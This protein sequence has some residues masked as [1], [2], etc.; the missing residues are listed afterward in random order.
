MSASVIERRAV[1]AT[2]LTGIIGGGLLVLT[3]VLCVATGVHDKFT[4][5][6]SDAI[7]ECI[8]AVALLMS[9]VA[10]SFS[11][12]A[13]DIRARVSGRLILAGQAAIA[14]AILATVVAGHE[15]WNVVYVAGFG[16]TVVAILAYAVLTRRWI[17]LVLAP[18]LVLALAA[19]AAGG[20]ILLGL[21]W[22]AVDHVHDR[23]LI[24]RV[25]TLH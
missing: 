20:P 24:H 6:R 13:L 4:G 15:V 10:L 21:A 12:R 19:F 9:P 23:S 22:L 16:I 25:P 18:A 2:R 1:N 3:G 8:W 17:V 7:V 11:T 5:D 14:L